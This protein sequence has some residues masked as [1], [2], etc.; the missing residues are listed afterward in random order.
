[1]CTAGHAT[2]RAAFSAGVARGI[3]RAA[4]LPT[5]GCG[6]LMTASASPARRFLLLAARGGFPASRVSKARADQRMSVCENRPPT[7]P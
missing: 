4:R 6:L 1:M 7:V 2:D 5:V 3:M